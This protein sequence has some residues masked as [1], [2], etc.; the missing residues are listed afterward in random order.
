MKIQY[1]KYGILTPVTF[2]RIKQGERWSEDEK[3]LSEGILKILQSEKLYVKYNKQS[4]K[5]A[6]MYSLEKVMMKWDRLIK[7]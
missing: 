7:K 2:G 1:C 5:R 4:L 3:L 6:S